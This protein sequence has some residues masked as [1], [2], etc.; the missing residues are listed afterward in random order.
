MKRLFTLIFFAGFLTSAF[1]QDDRHRQYGNQTNDNG[2]QL[3]KDSRNNNYG[4]SNSYPANNRY[5]KNYQGNNGNNENEH[6]YNS[7][8]DT[9]NA[10]KRDNWKNHNWRRDNR[11]GDDMRRNHDFNSE[12][13]NQRRVENYSHRHYR[14]DSFLR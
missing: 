13:G 7:D 10:D 14:R 5:D 8:R 12:Y 11:D 3:S 1:A 4:Y 9:R 6:F 2:Y